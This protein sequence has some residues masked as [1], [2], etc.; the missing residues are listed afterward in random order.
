MK[1]YEKFREFYNKCY[2]I[3]RF[4]Q[5]NKQLEVH[6][7]INFAR[8]NIEKDIL[9]DFIEIGRLPDEIIKLLNSSINI[10][11]FSTDN[12][13]KNIITHPELKYE[14]YCKIPKII[15]NPSKYYKIKTGYYVI[16]F[17][18]DKNY[19]K[20]VIKTTKSRKENFVKSLH[21][22]NKERYEKY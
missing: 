19:Y 22:L 15:K 18:E 9:N 14:D 6:E 20:L 5:K 3:V 11:K 1:K 2:S 7:Q 4:L 10:L 17:K 12:L 13:I 21:F 16:L 8:K